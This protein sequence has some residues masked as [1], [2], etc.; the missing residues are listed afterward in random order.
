MSQNAQTPDPFV[1][2]NNNFKDAKYD[3]QYT[4]YSN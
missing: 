1:A 2:Q 4:P 3:Q